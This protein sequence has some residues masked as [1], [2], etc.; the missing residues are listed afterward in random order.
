MQRCLRNLRPSFGVLWVLSLME[1]LGLGDKP[2]GRLRR[3]HGASCTPGWNY[4]VRVRPMPGGSESFKKQLVVTWWQ[5][6]ID[7]FPDMW[8]GFKSALSS[9]C[10]HRCLATS[11]HDLTLLQFG[12]TLV[13]SGPAIG[14]SEFFHLRRVFSYIHCFHWFLWHRLLARK[15]I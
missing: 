4:K 11:C 12:V 15:E 7:N 5:I 6:I 9:A 1:N 14:D 2:S 10:L 13:V 3:I 8:T